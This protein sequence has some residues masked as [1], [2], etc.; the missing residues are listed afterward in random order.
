MKSQFKKVLPKFLISP[1]RKIYIYLKRN[2]IRI[3]FIQ[4]YLLDMN[5]YL[6]YSRTFGNNTSTKLIASIILQYHVIE[7]GLTMPETKLGFGRE[8]IIA[9]CGE[10]SKYLQIYSQND[11]QVDHA[12]G[13]ILE[14]EEYHEKRHYNIDNEVKASIIH[15]KNMLRKK[16]EN[17]TQF[18]SNKNEYF[19]HIKNSFYEFS[20]SRASIRNF[21]TEDLPLE[22][23]INALDLARNAPSACN[24]Q[25]WRTYIILDKI[26]I[27]EI[28]TAQGGNRGFGHLVNKL[29]I[30]TGELGV[31]CYSNERNQVFIDGGIYSM[32]LLYALH[33]NAIAACILNCSFDYN[34]E[35]K[36]KSLVNIKG[37]EVLI[38]M[39]ACGLAPID[40][41]VSI[42]PRYSIKRTNTII[43]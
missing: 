1:L 27:S 41:N 2:Q 29:I 5:R 12:I 22:N 33:Y 9:L 13:I 30:V 35:Q 8:R 31:F 6:K 36:I 34:K 4:M 20:N 39:I 15:L 43:D 38:T 3:A 14:Y 10:C 21:S 37:S 42:S 28:L 40:F 11:E 19:K 17:K 24:R 16:V 23:L 26:K 32:N 7:K 18:H 25:S